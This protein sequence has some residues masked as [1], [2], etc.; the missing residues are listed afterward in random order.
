MP[1]RH[2]RFELLHSNSEHPNNST[3]PGLASETSNKGLCWNKTAFPVF[4]LG[5]RIASHFS[6]PLQ[7]CVELASHLIQCCL[8]SAEQTALITCKAD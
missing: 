4:V 7:H 5:V 2:P 3:S 6:V 1:Y 8:D